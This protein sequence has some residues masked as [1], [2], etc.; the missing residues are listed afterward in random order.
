MRG[1]PLKAVL[2][3]ADVHC[4]YLCTDRLFHNMK[5]EIRSSKSIGCNINAKILFYRRET[6]KTLDK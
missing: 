6:I 1:K 4:V 3:I 2:S 5:K